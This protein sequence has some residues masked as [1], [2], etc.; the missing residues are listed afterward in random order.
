VSRR[1]DRQFAV[2]AALAWA[3]AFAAMV[4]SGCTFRPVAP[5]V[6]DLP[7]CV[8][9]GEALSGPAVFDVYGCRDGR[10]EF[11]PRPADVPTPTPAPEQGVNACPPGTLRMTGKLWSR[12]VTPRC[13]QPVEA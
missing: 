10:I 6:P 5:A 3:A 7:E 9:I 1:S 4:A 11:R 8:Q 13:D 2:V 12:S